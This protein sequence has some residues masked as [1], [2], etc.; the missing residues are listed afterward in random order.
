M[1]R[2]WPKLVAN[3]IAQLE[4]LEEIFR[5]QPREEDWRNAKTR[6]VSIAE[7]YEKLT[8]MKTVSRAALRLA[9]RIEKADDT[10]G[11]SGRFAAFRELLV[12]DLEQ[13]LFFGLTA[14]ES[15][16][17]VDSPLSPGATKAFP[18]AADEL[19][20]ASRCLALG[21]PTA[22]SYHA[23]RALEVALTV[24]ARELQVQAGKNWHTAIE[25]VEKELRHR[26]GLKGT[27]PVMK[28]WVEKWDAFYTDAA[29]HF[30]HLK[31]AYRNPTMHWSTQA[32]DEQRARR[33]RTHTIELVESLAERVAEQP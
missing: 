4:E 1:F 19:W 5:R 17:Y 11:L 8:D 21:Q 7:D 14:E 2:I 3:V 23:V 25:Q 15:R 18:S 28:A 10:C 33:L 30:F 16:L 29:S 32:I 9:D 26:R 24:I 13:R 31:S 22:S 27:D 12:D 20:D 6:L